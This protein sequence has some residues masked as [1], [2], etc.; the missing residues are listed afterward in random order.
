MGR[1]IAVALCAFGTLAACQGTENID[2]NGGSQVAGAA[3]AD[4]AWRNILASTQFYE[5]RLLVAVGSI[6]DAERAT[7]WN[8]SARPLAD[9]D[10]CILSQIER[11]RGSAAGQIPPYEPDLTDTPYDARWDQ[12]IDYNDCGAGQHV[13]GRESAA[14]QLATNATLHSAHV[15]DL[16]L[17]GS[18]GESSYNGYATLET[19]LQ[20]GTAGVSAGAF[21]FDVENLYSL[22]PSDTSGNVITDPIHTFIVA[23]GGILSASS[24]GIQIVAAGWEQAGDAIYAQ[25]SALVYDVDQCPFLVE[26]IESGEL[27]PIPGFPVMFFAGSITLE[28]LTTGKRTEWLF[29]DCRMTILEDGEPVETLNGRE[30]ADQLIL[31]GGASASGFGG[32]IP[33]RNA[34]RLPYLESSHFALLTRDWCHAGLCMQFNYSNLIDPT[35]AYPLALLGMRRYDP[36]VAAA[37][38]HGTAFNSLHVLGLATT[39]SVD[40]AGTLTPLAEPIIADY[41]V[42]LT[43]APATAPTELWQSL[44]LRA[45]TDATSEIWS[46][47]AR[48]EREPVAAAATL[49]SARLPGQSAQILLPRGAH[50]PARP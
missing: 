36:L 42:S 11:L 27:I 40:G 23:R 5:D 38:A 1:R 25:S 10:A 28:S 16:R 14:L 18:A 37:E 2:R 12:V 47:V 29:Q 33:G 6:V 17:T 21:E 26:D 30:S 41:A 32:L 49:R 50:P 13:T 39:A 46:P 9:T 15:T 20:V 3:T 31:L 4:F 43:A 24:I 22:T 48:A 44:T 35:G 34:L 8:G 19:Y 45:I 7:D